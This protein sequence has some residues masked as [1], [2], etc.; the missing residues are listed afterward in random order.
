M[1]RREA[2]IFVSLAG[3]PFIVP[4]VVEDF[5]GGIAERVGLATGAAAFLLGGYLALQVWGIVGVGQ[6]RRVG[7]VITFWAS[8]VWTVVAVVDHG[9]AVL[10]GGFRSGALSVVW[11]LGLVLSQ[12]TA[13]ALAWRGWRR[14]PA[15]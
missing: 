13:A 5:A 14:E 3:L 1:T 11:V 9:P 7:W 8:A 12:G 10:A 6:G 15:S 2:T 4:H